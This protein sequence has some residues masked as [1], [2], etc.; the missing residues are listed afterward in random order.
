M[1]TRG[2]LYQKFGPLLIEALALIIKDEINELR[3]EQGMP[4]KTEQDILD[5]LDNKL[6]TLTKY[7]WMQEEG[8]L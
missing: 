2:E 1:V 4:E 5:T 7:A 8:G 6:N 3:A